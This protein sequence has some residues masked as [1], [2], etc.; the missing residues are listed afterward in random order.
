M[1]FPIPQ[2]LQPVLGACYLAALDPWITDNVWSLAAGQVGDIVVPV[3]YPATRH[4]AEPVIE[5]GG[6]CSTLLCS[7]GVWRHW[8]MTQM[9]LNGGATKRDAV[10]LATSA[11][12]ITWTLPSLGTFPSDPTVSGVDNIV[13]RGV[14]DVFASGISVIHAPDGSGFSYL[15]L[16]RTLGGLHIV[17]CVDVAGIEWSKPSDF[18]LHTIAVDSNWVVVPA[19]DDESWLLLSRPDDWG[20]TSQDPIDEGNQRRLAITRIP[21]LTVAAA[22]PVQTVLRVDARDKELSFHHI[23]STSAT[24]LQS[25]LYIALLHMFSQTGAQPIVP[26]LAWSRDGFY[27]ERAPD[28][29]PFLPLGDADEWDDGMLFPSTGVFVESGDEWRIYYAGWDGGHNVGARGPGEEPDPPTTR[30]VRTG[31]ATIGRERIA[32]LVGPNQGAVW[33]SRPLIV[34]ANGALFL[35]VDPQ[36]GADGAPVLVRIMTEDRRD[37]QAPATYGAIAGYAFDDCDPITVDDTRHAVTWADADF[38]AL[39][40]QTVRVEVY[41]EDGARLFGPVFTG[42]D[43][44]GAE[45]GSVYDP[46]IIIDGVAYTYDTDFGASVNAAVAGLDPAA[47]HR[48]VLRGAYEGETVIDLRAFTGGLAVDAIGL[49]ILWDGEGSPMRVHSKTVVIGGQ[50]RRAGSTRDHQLVPDVQVAGGAQVLS[51][52]GVTRRR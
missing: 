16:Y 13:W 26:F 43:S 19:T 9:A 49:R 50:V 28:R 5:D 41:I 30:T 32:A 18:V 1:R 21:S 34:P 3:F 12:G 52:T 42:T 44:R 25:G 4:G 45:M 6:F 35:N 14:G 51:L 40:G 48:I 24:K 20:S 37:P 8:Y 17:G 29:E 47:W 10:G 23:Y 46:K 7:D 39:A 36:T 31:L 2:P 22:E 38:A 15:M 33:S 11:D 27:W